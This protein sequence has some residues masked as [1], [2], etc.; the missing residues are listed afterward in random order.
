M[1]GKTSP[2]ASCKEPVSHSDCFG[3]IITPEGT[4]YFCTK[5]ECV[6]LLRKRL[7][8]TETTTRRYCDDCDTFVS[9]TGAH[10]AGHRIRSVLN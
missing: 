4:L 1:A 2:C 10:D 9:D 3:K 5:H 6:E 8:L 7:D